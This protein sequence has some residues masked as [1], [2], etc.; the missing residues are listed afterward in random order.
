MHTLRAWCNH[1]R[2]ITEFKVRG[3]RTPLTD[4]CLANTQQ[5]IGRRLVQ[6]GGGCNWD[7]Y[8]HKHKTTRV[9]RIRVQPPQKGEH[10]TLH[11][12]PAGNKQSTAIVACDLQVFYFDV[13]G[14]RPTATGG[15]E[16]T[17][18]ES[19]VGIVMHRFTYYWNPYKRQQKLSLS[20]SDGQRHSASLSSFESIKPVWAYDCD[21]WAHLRVLGV[22]V[23]QPV[24]IR[25]S[26]ASADAALDWSF[27]ESTRVESSRAK[28]SRAAP[29]V[30]KNSM[31]SII[32]SRILVDITGWM[33]NPL[34]PTL[35]FWEH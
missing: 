2:S 7:N 15:A 28:P 11:D 9:R 16:L 21:W 6:R 10:K 29:K 35:Y 22:F 18:A 3:Q 24:L 27:A 31:N 32:Q 8:K 4:K 26:S 13:R 14:P 5:P 17:R 33:D 34:P 1:S 12:T 30:G 23:S 25:Y 19:W 20:R